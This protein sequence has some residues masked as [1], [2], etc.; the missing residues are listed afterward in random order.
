MGPL[1]NRR[2]DLLDAINVLN[3]DNVGAYQ[4]S[5]EYNPDGE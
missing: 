4:E 3:R 1:A 5:L 2:S